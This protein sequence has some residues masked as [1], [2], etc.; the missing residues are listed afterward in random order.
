MD[1]TALTSVISSLPRDWIVIAVVAFLASY[2]TWRTGGR[3]VLSIVLGFPVAVL[4]FSMLP[5]AAF[6]SGIVAQFGTP[7]LGAILFLLVLFGTSFLMARISAYWGASRGPLGGVLIIAATVG[8]LIPLWIST[9]AL[10]HVWNFGPEARAIFGGAYQFWI[11]A[12]SYG[13]VA[14]ARGIV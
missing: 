1:T 9:P 4:I 7:A 12:L 6:I 11:V 3:Y 13:G 10:A 14:L 5:Q 2:D 8:I